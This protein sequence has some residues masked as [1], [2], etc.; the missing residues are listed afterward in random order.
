MS[1]HPRP[2]PGWAVS[3][4]GGS[5]RWAWEGEQ[6]VADDDGNAG[7]DAVAAAAARRRAQ[8]RQR[9]AN[10][11]GGRRLRHEVKVTD[12]EEERLRA[13]AVEQGV[14]VPR[15]LVEAALAGG[16]ETATQRRE[17][18]AELFAT[19]RLLAQISNNVNQIA[20]AVNATGDTPAQTAATLEAVRRTA[21]RIDVVLDGMVVSA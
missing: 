17:L 13:K 1:G 7:V 9:R 18:A 8:R 5:L 14:T 20:R 21:Q 4:Q 16:G 10:A 12:T 6:M 15:L 11:V 3:H 2:V 19:Y